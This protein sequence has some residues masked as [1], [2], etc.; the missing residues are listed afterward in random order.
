M[1]SQLC[2]LTCLLLF[3]YCSRPNFYHQKIND[4]PTVSPNFNAEVR[5]IGEELP[6]QP[7]FEIVEFDF[8][9]KGSFNKKKVR[10]FI[11]MEAIKEGV[12]AVIDVDFWDEW[13]EESN[14]LTVLMDVID[15][16]ME[17]TTI[18]AVYTHIRGRG[19]MYLDNLEFIKNQPEYEYVYKVDPMTGFPSPFFKIE[20]K[21][22]GKEHMVYPEAEGSLDVFRK[23]MQFYSDFHLMKQR[24]RWSYKMDGLRIKKRLLVDK[25]GNTVKV[26]V[27]RYDEKNQIIQIK[28]V[29]HNSKIDESEFVNYSYDQWGRVSKRLVEIH[30]G[31]KVYEDYIYEYGR[32]AK[33]RIRINLQD[34]QILLNTS[35]HY[36]DADYLRDYY[37][38]EVVKEKDPTK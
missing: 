19:I 32:L 13:N 10:K 11:E 17:S 18:S 21:L 20:Y 34:E 9:E 3:C 36:Y 15:E 27:P 8:V 30:D 31:S 38:N 35:L 37:F 14:F 29:H 16:D 33:K 4:I 25:N 24:D 1:K 7:Y 12:D 28:I 5:F 2:L 6:I 22:T 26:C 23:Y